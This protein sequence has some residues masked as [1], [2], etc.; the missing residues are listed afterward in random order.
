MLAGAGGSPY[1]PSSRAA[2]AL[3]SC[4][5]KLKASTTT[6]STRNPKTSRAM[7]PATTSF[8]A[9]TGSDAPSSS[10][11]RTA[12]GSAMATILP[13]PAAVSDPG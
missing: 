5:R 3:R 4:L 8:S 7:G 6:A 2:C 13:L 11:S 12:S 9:G 10:G 1:T